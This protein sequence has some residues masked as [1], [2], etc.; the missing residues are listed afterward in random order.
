MTLRTKMSREDRAKQF[1]PFAALKGYEE[2]LREREKI[3]VEKIELSEERKSELDLKLRQ[4]QRNDIIT[5]VYFHKDEYL[6]MTGMVSR[7]DTDARILKVVNTKI[8]FGDL[9]DLEEET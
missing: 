5:V 8:E 7:I 9:Y 6:K 1:M 4:V 3:V 2:A